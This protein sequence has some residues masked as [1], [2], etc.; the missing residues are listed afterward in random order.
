MCRTEPRLLDQLSHPK[1]KI[2]FEKLK[3][4]ADSVRLLLF[5]CVRLEISQQ[6]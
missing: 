3:P 1:Q 5:F 4:M 6:N 2:A